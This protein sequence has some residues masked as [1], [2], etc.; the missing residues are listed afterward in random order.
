MANTANLPYLEYN[1]KDANDIPQGAPQ[2]QQL[3]MVSQG[4]MAGVQMAKDAIKEV[5]GQYNASLGQQSN[6]TSGKAIIARQR[7]GDTATY[8][9][10]DGLQM[11][12]EHLGRIEIDMTPRIYDT[13]RV[14]RIL[15][16]DDSTEE[17]RIDPGQ[18]EAVRETQINA[19]GEVAKIY[20][21]TVG[22][23]DVIATVG[24]S[25]TTKRAEAVEAMTQIM[26]GN[27]NVFPLIGDIWVRNQDWPGS[28][29]I[30]DRMKTLLP[31]EIQQQEKTGMQ[32]PPQVAQQMQQMQQQM[33]QMQ[34]ALQQTQGAL[35]QAQA[36]NEAKI[37]SSQIQAQQRMQEAKLQAQT[38]IAVAQI[39]MEAKA[40]IA[41]M[42]AKI[43]AQA[44]IMKP[45]PPQ[46]YESIKIPQ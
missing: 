29:E 35:Q 3:Q 25:F 30:S 22:R 8:H 11:A 45:H 13:K 28:D 21:L 16:E 37:Q 19:E 14:M 15:G 6:E 23:Y 34:Q 38:D 24:P 42:E 20:N 5:T 41:H 12:I 31:P 27:P 39:Q 46:V 1:S 40:Q 44:E 17:V 43:K 4:L 36:G 10:I 18:P 9:F 26:Q 33:Q 7:E 32:I 2:R